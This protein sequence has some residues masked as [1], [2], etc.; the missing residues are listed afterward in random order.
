MEQFGLSFLLGI[1]YGMVLFLIAVG[2][3]VVLGFM[4][5]LNLAHG[6]IFMIGGYTG[7]T[8]AR[9][10]DNF[11]YGILAGGLASG[12]L[13]LLM[14][15]GV[16]RF[17]YKQILDQVLVTFGFVYIITNAAYWI[18]GTFPMAAY[19][20]SGLAGSI[21]IG[22][23]QFPLHRLT[24]LAIGGGV[25]LG[26]WW[27]Q[28][29]TRYGAVVRAGMDD[30]QMVSGLGINVVPIT[31]ATF[32][33]GSAL[34]GSAA[35]LGGP[36]LGFVNPGTGTDI[37]FI[38]L[39]VVIVGGV[40][41]VQGTLAGALIIG[42]I[43]TLATTYVPG[44]AMF[45]MYLL[46]V[47]ILLLRPSG[48]LGRK[49]TQADD[50]KGKARVIFMP[51]EKR[52]RHLASYLVIPALVMIIGFFATVWPLFAPLY[53][54]SL[55]TKVLI[56]GLLVMSLDLLVGFSG[57][58]SFCQASLFGVAAYTTGLLVTRYGVTSFWL[59]AP[60]GLL[61]AMF[62]AAAI[63]V[64][65]LR[66]SAV[67]FLLITFALGQLIYGV[68]VRWRSIAGDIGLTG[69]PYP[70]LGFFSWD[71][72]VG[73]Y[74][75]V[76]I[77]FLI[78]ALALYLITKSPFGLSLQGIRDNEIRM[79]SLGYNTWLYK[80]LSF[81]IGGLFAGVAGILYIHYNGL[82]TPVDINV[83]ASGFLWLMLI[84]GGAGTLWGALL[85]SC[86]IISLQYIISI[87][88][89]EHWPLFIGASFIASVVFLR[90]G[91]FRYLVNLWENVRPSYAKS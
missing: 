65:S 46:M 9:S 28:E 2:L 32:F 88:T 66:V 84:I 47:L 61:M 45:S 11:I 69:V 60:A 52:A 87:L 40:G 14:E 62:A 63:G 36:I 38:A 86:V 58:W 6:V 82:I 16:L 90:G 75:F 55:L 44:L 56:F 80:F 49:I 76:L 68:A 83:S 78:C 10:T 51:V 34:A 1:S 27:L 71:S 3:S 30:V 54:V 25:C 29:K 12:I 89:P 33:L 23:V 50:R 79:S 43:N 85:G 39:A 31:I 15:R 35:I 18:W 5:I 77:V 81:V 70:A 8:V 42:V 73:M 20:P 41:S 17:L 59:S 53:I 48:L 4:G 22:E 67:Y 13:G 64:I 24:I 19:V 72:P 74:Y 57:L 37:L 26:L 91:I 7:I 21:S